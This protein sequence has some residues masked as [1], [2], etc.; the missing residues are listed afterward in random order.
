MTRLIPSCGYSRPRAKVRHQNEVPPQRL[1]SLRVLFGLYGMLW[2]VVRMP[3]HLGH[4]DQSAA[5]WQPIGVLSFFDNPLPDAV[6]VGLAVGTPLLGVLYVAGWRFAVTGPAFAGALLALATLDSSWGQIFHVENLMVLHVGILALAPGTAD[7]SLQ[8][9][10]R[11]RTDEDDAEPVPAV[12]ATSVRYA[13]PIRLAQVVVV[14]AYMVAGLAKLDRA[15]I[16]WGSGEMLRNLVAHDNLRKALLGDAYS[17]VGTTLVSQAWLF[18]VLAVTSLG[19][20]LGAWVALLGGRLRTL[21]VAAAWGFH[22]GIFVL[23]AILFP[24][25][26]TGM[27]FAPFFRVE[28]LRP[29]RWLWARTC[30]PGAKRSLRSPLPPPQKKQLD[31]PVP[32]G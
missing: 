9:A 13:W 26:L 2:A 23:M 3:A 22:V 30:P 27:A 29:F 24:Y 21:W 32:S 20:E 16:G 14:L 18:P 6:V 5:R 31:P 15:G 19:V 7:V 11:R 10:F 28:R 1:A 8:G 17:P 25:Q 4:L 12:G